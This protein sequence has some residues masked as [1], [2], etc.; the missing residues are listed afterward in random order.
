MST[1]QRWSVRI[2]VAIAIAVVLLVDLLSTI[3]AWRTPSRGPM[4]EGTRLADGVVL[5]YD[6]SDGATTI[7][8]EVRGLRTEP[9]AVRERLYVAREPFAKSDF[10]ELGR[11]ATLGEVSADGK[12]VSWLESKERGERTGPGRLRG[13]EKDAPLLRERALLPP[14]LFDREGARAASITSYLAAPGRGSLHH[15]DLAAGTSKILS[16]NV[17]AGGF[18]WLAGGRVFVLRR[19]YSAT[20]AE[21]VVLT[22]GGAPPVAVTASMDS[23]VPAA[24]FR[25]APDGRS[26]T[27]RLAPDAAGRRALV[28]W[29]DD[30]VGL[31][32]VADDAAAW[33]LDRHGRAWWVAVDGRAFREPEV[34]GDPVFLG[35]AAGRDPVSVHPLPSGAGVWIVLADRPCVASKPERLGCKRVVLAGAGAAPP[36]VEGLRRIAAPPSGW[37]VVLLGPVAGNP[38][39]VAAGDPAA[40]IVVE[41]GGLLG[42]AFS[43]DGRY[44]GARIAATDGQ[45]IVLL[46]FETGVV[47]TLAEQAP[48]SLLSWHGDALVFVFRNRWWR[49]DPR[50]G[51]YRVR[52]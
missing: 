25:I 7:I 52:P 29:S 44:A 28:R 37:P 24:P 22:P 31:A 51:L 1:W 49:L 35:E 47:T 12:F 16:P 30:V 15:F 5:G 26:V 50:N 11:G 9:G 42:T 21:A 8:A 23:E 18:G 46:D 39:L 17:P 19:P 27:M 33:T 14:V 40:P 34:P 41:D 6:A 13:V 48:E 38:A 32:R 4:P 10:E 20:N 2:P 36:V 43:P 3:G 45:R